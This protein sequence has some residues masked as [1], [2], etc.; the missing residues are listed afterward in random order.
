[1]TASAAA[2]TDDDK[3]VAENIGGGSA[4]VAAGTKGERSAASLD[5]GGDDFIGT[6]L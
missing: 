3:E 2:S 5:L 6:T 4:S 1:M